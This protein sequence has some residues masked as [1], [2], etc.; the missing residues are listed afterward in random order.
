MALKTGK[1]LLQKADT[2]NAY[3]GDFRGVDF[4]S[5]HTQVLANRFAYAVN[6]FKDY[7]SGQGGSI[8]TLPGF[9]RV[10]ETPNGEKINA[11]HELSVGGKKHVLVHAGNSLYRWE[12]FPNPVCVEQEKV[13]TLHSGIPVANAPTEMLSFKLSF[14]DT[15]VHRVIKVVDQS[16]EECQAWEFDLDS[17]ALTVSSGALKD[18]HTV[19]VTYCEG[20][21]GKSLYTMANNKSVSFSMNGKGY[22]LDGV[23]YL[24]YDELGVRP[25]VNEAYVPTTRVGIVPAANDQEEQSDGMPYE[26][27]NLL[28]PSFKQTFRANGETFNFV[29]HEK[30]ATVTNVSVHG[31]S[32]SREK[33]YIVEEEENEKEYPRVVFTNEAPASD[34]DFHA[35]FYP[36]GYKGLKIDYVDTYL[37]ADATI[38]FRGTIS[39]LCDG[40]K[41]FNLNETVPK[42]PDYE[43]DERRILVSKVDLYGQTVYEGYEIKRNESD[44]TVLIF[45]TAPTLPEDTV[46]YPNVNFSKDYFGVEITARK[47]L[48][49]IDGIG[50]FNN[51]H[52]LITKCTKATVFDGRVFLSGNPGC[53]NRVFY[54]GRNSDGVADPSYF[55]EYDHFADGSDAYPIVAMMPV[56]DVLTVLKGDTIQEGSI[57]YHAPTETQVNVTPKIYPAKEGLGGI[58]CLGACVN[59][60]DDPVFVSRDGLS[61]IGQLSVRYERAIEHR[62]TLVD[63]KLTNEELSNAFLTE[64]EGYLLLFVEGRMYMAD[65]RQRYADANG[66]MQYEWYYAEGIGV[67]EDQYAEYRFAYEKP[68]EDMSTDDGKPI[69]LASDVFSYEE[70]TSYDLRGTVVNPPKEDGTPSVEVL[71]NAEGFPYVE[72]DG[73]P[74]LCEPTGAMTGGTK[75]HP[76]TCAYSSDGDLFFGTN[77]GVICMFNFD[78]RDANGE[79][80]S[81]WYSFDGRTI[82]SG[83]AT[84]MD[85]CGIP[86]LTKNTV[87]KSMVVKTKT[88]DRSALK[89]KVR[90]N[91]NPYNQ[92]ARVNAARFDFENMDFAD[93]S[94]TTDKDFLFV[95]RE[96]EKKW[97]EKQLYLFNDEFCKPFSLFYIAYRYNV[98]GKYKE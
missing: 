8:D 56:A 79:I 85:N 18:G 88:R 70:L 82:L 55:G 67:Y 41:E 86:H 37:T 91:K 45:E 21:F 62:S 75:F 44:E 11:I 80:P 20:D 13:F 26:Q 53:P 66:L 65:S 81:K 43:F 24:M 77:N 38:G 95:I 60:L 32:A 42:N 68:V 34:V 96:K 9:R 94:A 27:R 4:S 50:S 57:Y 17:K 78:K 30:G 69:T 2:Y 72:I 16:G 92:V 58:G 73:L 98:A 97:V 28:T 40:K 84:K 39:L 48:G 71:F 15:K 54:C 29:V 90:T 12:D 5:D 1:N 23:D 10:V 35:A 59:F 93:F 46:Y 22:I 6:M 49:K 3:Y 51:Q 76:A 33:D 25:V 74:Y 14:G 63:A 19:T 89:V 61:A 7:K 36:K 52:M 31:E 47:T 87:K 64:W 83:C